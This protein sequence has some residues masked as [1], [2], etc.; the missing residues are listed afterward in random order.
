[1]TNN[2]G[3]ATADR[4]APM[5][6]ATAISPQSTKTA[7]NVRKMSLKAAL[8]ALP[9]YFMLPQGKACPAGVKGK[10]NLE[11]TFLLAHNGRI[12][13]ADFFFERI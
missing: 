6:E 10:R 5:T 12:D 9:E 2:A 7:M 13:A 4:I 11:F 1:M 8:L 3:I